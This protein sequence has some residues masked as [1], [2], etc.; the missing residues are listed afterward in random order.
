MVFF[1]HEGVL[2][3]EYDSQVQT[4]K[5]K[6]RGYYDEIAAGNW[7]SWDSEMLQKVQYERK[8][9]EIHEILYFKGICKLL[10]TMYA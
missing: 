3:H 5:I 1:E 4:V 2:Y 6:Y 8:S 7:N 9:L 10:F